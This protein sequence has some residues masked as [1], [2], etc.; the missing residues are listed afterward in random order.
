[1]SETP[2]EHI[3]NGTKY[4]IGLHDGK[5][6]L[7]AALQVQSVLQSEIVGLQGEVNK[8]LSSDDRA[9]LAE[10][11]SEE[12][13]KGK[14]KTKA[15]IESDGK[16]AEKL[17]LGYQGAM[18]SGAESMLKNLDPGKLYDMLIMLCENVLANGMPLQDDKF[19]R[20]HFRKRYADV[21]PLVRAVIKEN[22]FLDLEIQVL[23]GDE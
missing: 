18:I 23:V 22:G 6:G 15:Q 5:D 10:L 14:K 12:D 17:M 3:I 20:A 1:M 13:D 7:R 16:E 19:F 9:K 2:P 8:A 11:Q 4:T 21:Y